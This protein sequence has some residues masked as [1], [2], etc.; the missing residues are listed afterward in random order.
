[1]CWKLPVWDALD[2]GDE[3]IGHYRASGSRQCKTH[4]RGPVPRVAFAKEDGQTMACQFP[5]SAKGNTGARVEPKLP[6]SRA[7]PPESL[8]P[9]LRGNV[10]RH[11]VS[12]LAT[13]GGKASG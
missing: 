11:G 2:R 8:T 10:S 6:R 5:G 13:T 7:Q 9:D 4:T 3:Q 12:Y 1:M